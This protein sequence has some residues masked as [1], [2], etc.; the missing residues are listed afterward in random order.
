VAALRRAVGRW[1]S[2]PRA[3]RR[4]WRKRATAYEYVGCRR[5]LFCDERDVHLGRS[6]ARLVA[7]YPRGHPARLGHSTQV[8]GVKLLGSARETE[9]GKSLRSGEAALVAGS[10]RGKTT[11]E[12]A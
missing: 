11:G 9:L 3:V 4:S 10:L 1:H 7:P 5:I 12:A 8:R 6:H 2:R